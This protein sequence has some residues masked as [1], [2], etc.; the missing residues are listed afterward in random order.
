LDIFHNGRGDH[1]DIG[2][3]QR[4]LLDSQVDQLT[5]GRILVLE[6][7][8]NGE[9]QLCGLLWWKQFTLVYQP[10][11]LGQKLTALFGIDRQRVEL[12][13][14]L[15]EDRHFVGHGARIGVQRFVGLGGHD[16]GG[17]WW[18]FFRVYVYWNNGMRTTWVN[19]VGDLEMRVICVFCIS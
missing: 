14:A 15:L 4:K 8:G 18:M 5:Q 2:Q 16:G 12:L 7:L 11:Q 1:Q 6:Q 19:L 10:Q 13:Q 17:L 9:K 3:S